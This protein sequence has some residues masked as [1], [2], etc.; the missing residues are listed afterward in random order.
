MLAQLS[1]GNHD[2]HWLLNIPGKNRHFIS[3]ARCF[4]LYL[5]LRL[6]VQQLSPGL[7]GITVTQR[8]GKMRTLSDLRKRLA[9]R[10]QFTAHQTLCRPSLR[11][12][13][14]YVT[15]SRFIG[16]FGRCISSSLSKPRQRL[17]LLAATCAS[18]T[19]RASSLGLV[20]S[21]SL[22]RCV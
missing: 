18:P 22:M 2:N 3:T 6:Y 11:L 7:D 17:S 1:A 15:V 19:P 8:T 12:C 21:T 9:G 14:Y 16:S 4:D 10:R 5:G 13:P 20:R